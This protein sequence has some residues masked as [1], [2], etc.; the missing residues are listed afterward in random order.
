MSR[1]PLPE[2]THDDVVLQLWKLKGSRLLKDFVI[3]LNLWDLGDRSHDQLRKQDKRKQFS[4]S[5]MQSW[6]L[7]RRKPSTRD[8]EILRRKIIWIRHAHPTRA[9]GLKGQPT[10]R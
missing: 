5:A 8:A 9:R 3:E 4:Y 2:P 6:F 1:K 10:A 7:Q